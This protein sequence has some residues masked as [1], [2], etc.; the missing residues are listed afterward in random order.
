MKAAVFHDKNLIL[1]LNKNR[2]YMAEILPYNPIQS[3]DLNSRKGS[4][5]IIFD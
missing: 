5:I 3:T 1:F 4:W 2:R